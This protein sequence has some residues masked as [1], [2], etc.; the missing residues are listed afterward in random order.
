MKETMI[1]LKK[2]NNDCLE[3]K[4][5]IYFIPCSRNISEKVKQ[6]RCIW[7]KFLNKYINFI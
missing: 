3:I 1:P 7:S 2:R 5:V 4:W 6:S